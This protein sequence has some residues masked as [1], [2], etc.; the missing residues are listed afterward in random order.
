M[1]TEAEVC[2][3]IILFVLNCIC[4]PRMIDCPP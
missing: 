2:L 1:S 4:V 3:V